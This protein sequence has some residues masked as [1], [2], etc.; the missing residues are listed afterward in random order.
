MKIAFISTMRGYRWGGSEELWRHAANHALDERHTVFV[1]VFQDFPLADKIVA[2]QNKGAAIFDNRPRGVRIFRALEGVVE[3]RIFKV[4][5]YSPARLRSPFRKLFETKPDVI[6]ISEGATYDV[7][8]LPDLMSLLKDSEIPYMTVSQLAMDAL[9][10]WEERKR[11]AMRDFYERAFCASFV[12]EDNLRLVE[13]Q[14]AARL[15]N[16]VV[17]R[18]PINL[19][20]S[21]AS[22]PM[23]DAEVVNFASVARLDSYHKGQDVLFESLAKPEWRARGWKLNLY[24]TGEHLEYLKKLARVYEITDRVNFAGHAPD[25]NAVWAQNHLLVM[26]SRHE[27]TP[28]SMVEAMICGRPTVGTD[29]G[30]IN[31]WLKEP[32]TGFLAEAPRADYFSA[33]LERAWNARADWTKIGESARRFALEHLSRAP[34]KDFLDIITSGK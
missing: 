18:N 1:S 7:Y 22:V 25:I 34:G 5:A 10:P 8:T 31:E 24:G 15:P 21:D 33:A 2:L 6:C 11:D 13:R 23:P 4:E 9:V 32:E 17:V 20:G 29:V 12:S 14:L 19:S 27:G 3:R 26:A 30:G 28:L 16:G